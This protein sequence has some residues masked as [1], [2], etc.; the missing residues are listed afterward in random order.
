MKQ[1]LFDEII[2]HRKADQIAQGH[3]DQENG[4]VN[5]F[6]P[7]NVRNELLNNYLILCQNKHQ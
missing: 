7:V 5:I 1:L 4:Q 3:Y 2:K 6:A